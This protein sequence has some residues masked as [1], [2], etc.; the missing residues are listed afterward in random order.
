MKCLAKHF[1]ARAMRAKSSIRR[2]QRQGGMATRYDGEAAKIIGGGDVRPYRWCIQSG[3]MGAGGPAKL[4][5][6]W[7]RDVG[8]DGW[9]RRWLIGLSLKRR[10]LRVIK[11]RE[12]KNLW[13]APAGND[14]GWWRRE[15]KCA[16]M[17]VVRW[18]RRCWPRR[19][20]PAYASC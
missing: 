14:E 19:R 16:G 12:K 11:C 18:R 9:A 8:L 1:L 20:S 3:R 15:M 17:S 2:N 7:R 10:K 5:R 6:R 13:A 4:S